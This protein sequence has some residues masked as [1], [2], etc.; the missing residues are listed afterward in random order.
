M[1]FSPS[2]LAPVGPHDIVAM[3]PGD[4]DVLLLVDDVPAV[5]ADAA[6]LGRADILLFVPQI[7]DKNTTRL[8]HHITNL[9]LEDSLAN[10]APE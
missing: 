8:F 4:L 7:S 5:E 1:V 6:R 2:Y 10:R 9:I 3:Y